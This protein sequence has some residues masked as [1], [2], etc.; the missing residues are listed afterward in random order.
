M[1]TDLTKIKNQ[2]KEKEDEN[3]R[4][5]TFLKIYDDTNLDSIVHKLL[6]QVSKAIDCTSCGNCCREVQPILNNRDINK[7]AKSLNIKP[8]Q[9]ITDY[10]KKDED[11]DNVLK[12]I[13]CPFLSD[14]KCTQYD[15]R[16]NDCA[17]YPHLHKQEFVFRLI[18][19]INNYSVCPI[20]FNV[21]EALKEKLKSQFIAFQEEFD[22]DEYYYHRSSTLRRNAIA[23]AYAR[24]SQR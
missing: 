2:A 19:V 21:Y 1:E 13:P 12:Q 15:S 14:N 17:S 20:V 3:W 11:G 5:R 16:P 18:G 7:L 9:F 23:A 4:F 6:E 22:E 10:V 24:R 8:D